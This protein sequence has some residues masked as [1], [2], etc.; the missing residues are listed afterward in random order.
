MH[1]PV[2]KINPCDPQPLLIQK[3]ADIIS[4][5]GVIS[6]PTRCLYGLGADAFNIKAVERIFQIKKRPLEKPILILVKNQAQISR[7]VTDIPEPAERI[8]KKYWPGDVTLIFN[9]GSEV[10]EIL[11]AGTGKIGIRMPSHKIAMALC[12]A[13]STPI[14]GT[15]ANLSGE[16]GYAALSD[17]H[18]EIITQLDLV[19]DAGGLAG[20]V[21]S[22]V[23]D[24]TLNPPAVLREGAV[25]S[26]NILDFKKNISS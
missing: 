24:V 1:D 6:F 22:T 26:K 5:G 16:A 2:I 25:P 11:T 17:F 23:I 18:P 8:M 9:A 14:T 10:P 4:G 20:G 3:A 21:G 13:L 12:N 19:I 15:S 7:L